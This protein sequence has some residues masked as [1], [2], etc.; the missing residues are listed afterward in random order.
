MSASDLHIRVLYRYG[1]MNAKV[2]RSRLCLSCLLLFDDLS[3]LIYL[4]SDFLFSPPFS[5]HSLFFHLFFNSFLLTFPSFSIPINFI[6]PHSFRLFFL[7]L[8][9]ITSTF[10]RQIPFS[11]LFFSQF[12]TGHSSLSSILLNRSSSYTINIYP[13]CSFRNLLIFYLSIH[14]CCTFPLRYCLT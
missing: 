14:F 13:L 9:L 4:S 1:E 2:R 3:F 10:S 12:L 7:S 6:V 5:F 8:F 11:F